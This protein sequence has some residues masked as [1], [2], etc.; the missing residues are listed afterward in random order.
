MF[1]G[2]LNTQRLDMLY[3]SLMS[4]KSFLDVFLT[5]PVSLCNSMSIVTLSQLGHAMSIAFKLS[6]IEVPGWDIAHVRS[7][8]DMNSYFEQLISRFEQAGAQVDNSQAVPAKR[9]FC[10]GGALA[11]GRVKG[12]YDARVAADAEKGRQ[13][14]LQ[15]GLTGMEDLLSGEKFD[16]FDDMYLLGDWKWEDIMGDFMQ[17]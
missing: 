17:E 15:T 14:E 8:V 3:A 7:T 6:F 10:S 16:D 9:S 12:W 11:L 13:E 4:A 5:L 2:N 1:P